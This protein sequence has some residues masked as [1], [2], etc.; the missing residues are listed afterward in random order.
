MNPRF[1]ALL[2][3]SE[4]RGPGHPEVAYWWNRALFLCHLLRSDQSP[5][6]FTD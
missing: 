5:A 2:A 1:M 4:L 6:A 3:E